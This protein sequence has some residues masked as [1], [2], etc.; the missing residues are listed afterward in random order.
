M[1]PFHSSYLP[2]SSSLSTRPVKLPGRAELSP[3]SILVPRNWD[4]ESYPQGIIICGHFVIKEN[5]KNLVQLF[6][7]SSFSLPFFPEQEGWM[8][9]LVAGS[10]GLQ[11]EMGFNSRSKYEASHCSGDC[12]YGAG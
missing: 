1:E 3:S 7:D 5:C 11:S 12:V 4:A 8:T 10:T 2:Q 6:G 9:A